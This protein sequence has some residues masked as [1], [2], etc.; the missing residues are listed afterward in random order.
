LLILLSGCLSDNDLTRL[1]VRQYPDRRGAVAAAAVGAM[2]VLGYPIAGAREDV[3]ELTILSG[4]GPLYYTF[5]VVLI[6]HD[7][8]TT[9][10]PR[11][12]FNPSYRNPAL[13][14][15]R[16]VRPQE[17]PSLY[18]D[19]FNELERRLGKPGFGK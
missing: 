9:V 2:Q 13:N 12:F 17:N 3:G 4:V 5:Q 7:Q 19:F 11:L 18:R 16:S 6:E 15:M 10:Q 8:Q 14:P 1:E